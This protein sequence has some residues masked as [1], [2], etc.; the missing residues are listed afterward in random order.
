M[1][2][3]ARHDLKFNEST[4]VALGVESL[5]HEQAVFGISFGSEN[6]DA[7]NDGALLPKHHSVMALLH[8]CSISYLTSR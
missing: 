8:C 3:V 7:T 4:C 2:L 5:R 6:A 1:P